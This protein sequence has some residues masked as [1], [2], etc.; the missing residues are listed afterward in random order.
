MGCCRCSFSDRVEGGMG[1]SRDS[2]GEANRFYA[3]S[4]RRGNLETEIILSLLFA[5]Q[6]FVKSTAKSV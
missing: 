1:A 3:I 6:V 4:P 5:K 2:K